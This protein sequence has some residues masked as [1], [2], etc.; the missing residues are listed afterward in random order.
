MRSASIFQPKSPPSQQRISVPWM[1]FAKNWSTNM[2]IWWASHQFSAS[3]RTSPSKTSSKNR[4]IQTCLPSICRVTMPKFSK[5]WSETLLAI[6]RI[7]RPFGMSS[8][9]FTNSVSQLPHQNTGS[10]KSCFRPMK[11]P[12]PLSQQTLSRLFWQGRTWTRFFL[13]PS[14]TSRTIMKP[15]PRNFRSP[16]STWA[17]FQ[18]S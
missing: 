9:R 18:L 5:N 6:G 3:W 8:T 15:W 16:T 4:S 11:I 12:K 1:P 10:R 2:V 17:M 7:A 13:R 14:P